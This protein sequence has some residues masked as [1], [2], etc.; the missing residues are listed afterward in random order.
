MQAIWKKKKRCFI[1]L[2]NYVQVFCLCSDGKRNITEFFPTF[3]QFNL[4]STELNRTDLRRKYYKND[5]KIEN[6]IFYILN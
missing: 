2:K 1:S 6:R 4:E 3:N 5:E